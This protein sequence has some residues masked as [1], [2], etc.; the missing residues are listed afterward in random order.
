MNGWFRRWLLLGAAAISQAASLREQDIKY[1][2]ATRDYSIEMNVASYEPYLGRRLAFS[3]SADARADFCYS[4]DG[5][6]TGT[7]IER[8]VGA[9]AVVTYVVKLANGR[10][11]KS[12][13]IRE[14][15]M[16]S[17]QSANLPGRA[18][19]SMTQKLIEGI[20]SDV[21]AFGYDEGPLK[22]GVRAETRREAQALWWR[23][24]RQELYVGE[25]TSPFAIVQW[26][27]TLGRVSIIRVDSVASYAAGLPLTR[28]AKK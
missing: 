4:T 8:F 7:C 18:P 5:S 25:E 28:S 21:Q 24:C 11:P 13:T 2:F 12:A 20:G 3:S 23:L 27:Y 6:T 22:R 9:I 1:S 16:V 19:F 14:Y 26:K 10:R 15:V 17:A